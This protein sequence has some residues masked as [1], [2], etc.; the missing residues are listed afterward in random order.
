MSMVRSRRR[1]R[2][3]QAGFTLVEILI[4]VALMLIGIVTVMGWL[5][6]AAQGLE[7]GRRQSTAMFLAEQRLEQIKAWNAS[8]AGGQGYASI[9][10]GSPSA[11]ACCAAEAY[12]AIVS[13]PL[14]RRQVNVT[15]GPTANTRSIQVLV[16][17]RPL[18]GPES[19][20]QLQTLLVDPTVP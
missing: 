7:T 11:A 2:A 19:Q 5:P 16:F 8:A 6:L 9:A 12:S 13:Y 1:S 15:A 17:Y 20:V 14:Y 18:T 4:A 3:T 10:I